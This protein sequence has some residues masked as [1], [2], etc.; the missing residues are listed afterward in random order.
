VARV[1]TELMD[2][3]S[4]LDAGDGRKPAAGGTPRAVPRRVVAWPRKGRPGRVTCDTDG[5]L[6]IIDSDALLALAVRTE[7][8]LEVVCRPGRYAIRET[9]IALVWPADSADSELAEDVR[10]AFSFGNQRT[11]AQDLEFPVD[12]LVEVAVRALSP[13]VNDPFTAVNCVDRLGSALAQ[14]AR[15][16][17]VSPDRSDEAGA[18]RVLIPA[19][20]FPGILDAAFNPIRQSAQGSAPVSIR[21]LEV[22]QVIAIAASRDEDRK[23]IGRQARMIARGACEVLS[24]EDDR[25]AVEDRLR[26]VLGQ[27]AQTAV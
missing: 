7:T 25:S 16:D 8:V 20:R 14:L 5:Y 4:G 13:G 2:S 9:P 6:Q 24:E 17:L 26:G 19:F 18:T 15:I 3:I 1:A 23:A 10:A 12:Q 11:S 27:L 21:L 22:L